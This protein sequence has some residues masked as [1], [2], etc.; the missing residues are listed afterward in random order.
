MMN[1]T[2]FHTHKTTLVN[3]TVAQA[4]I[5]WKYQSFSF[6]TRYRPMEISSTTPV[7]Q[8]KM[9]DLAINDTDTKGLF[10]FWAE[11]P[12]LYDP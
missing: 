8:V 7:N 4:V 1:K 12:F 9:L 11:E 2:D 6:V 5:D 3:V 10:G